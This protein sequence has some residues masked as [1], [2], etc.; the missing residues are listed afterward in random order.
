MP[1][2][3]YKS[4][5]LDQLRWAY[6]G[7]HFKREPRWH[8]MVSLAFAEKQPRVCF[9]HGVGSGKTLIAYYVAQRKRCQNILVV[10]PKHAVSS[11]IRDIQWTDYTYTVISGETVERKARMASPTNVHITPY[12][13]LKTVFA[14]LKQSPGWISV[15][16]GLN[17]EKAEKL[18]LT[19][20]EYK[21]T[22]SKVCPGTFDVV[23]PK[24]RKWSIDVET[25]DQYHFD[26][27][28]LDEVHRCS[29]STSRQSKI[30][31]EISK[32]VKY[33]TALT[34]TPVDKV[35]LELFNIYLT[36]DQGA[37]FGTN[38]WQFRLEHF[39]ESFGY[40]YQVR[41]GHREIILQRAMWNTL[42]FSTDECID[43]PECAEDVMLLEPTKE[44][45]RLEKRLLLEKP[46]GVAGSKDVFSLPSTRATKLKQLSGGFL[47]LSNDVVYCLKENPKLEAVID[48]FQNTGEKIIIW[49]TFVQAGNL[50]AEALESLDKPIQFGRIQGGMT[51]EEI[52]E[53]QRKFQED[54]DVQGLIVQTTCNE[55]WDGFAAGVTVFWD[56][57][58]SPRQREQCVGR[59]VRVGQE[60]KTIVYDLVL[61]DTVDEEARAKSGSRQKEIDIYMKY[62]QDYQLRCKERCR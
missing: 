12:H 3:D 13:A 59:M 6:D 21:V 4:L 39:Q 9:W 45:R 56:I 16:T 1:K 51:A 5:T 57:V 53:T 30:C 28:I 38:F 61:Q 23:K 19:K 31:Q 20:K 44:F 25:L 2:F 18:R 29:S 60:K 24:G 26:C 47:Y 32:R 22:K 36:V 62:M 54:P 52:V 41:K 48:L 15:G 10:C 7:V 14:S 33:V 49:Y 43:L 35:L 8:Q 17:K 58:I 27:L 40:D 50:I 55:G 34:G 42:S 37:T 46:I 11:W